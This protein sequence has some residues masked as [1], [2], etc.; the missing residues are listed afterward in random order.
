MA[1]L[2]GTQLRILQQAEYDNY[3]FLC[4]EAGL[5][6]ESFTMFKIRVKMEKGNG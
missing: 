2:T 6:P 5:D 4:R 3:A 1:T